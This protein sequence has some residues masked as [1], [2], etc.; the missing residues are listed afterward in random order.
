MSSLS[1][2]LVDAGLSRERLDECRRL[3]N[4]SGD[5]LDRAIL[6]RAYL[7]EA[8]LLEVYASHLGYDFEGQLEGTK[9][10]VSFID[11]VPVHFS[12]N[13][14][15]IA[16]GT[17]EDGAL[18]VATCAPLEP[19]PMDDLAAMLGMDVEPVLSP[20]NEI[21]TLIARAYRHKADGVNQALADVAE[22]GDIAGLAS[23]ISDAEDVLDV[24][25]KAPIIKLV[26]TILFQ[27]LKLR[28]SD[29]HFHPYEDRTQVRFRIDGIL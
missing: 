12:R 19:Q 21:T 17:S 10:P 22:D 13:Y 11:A 9:V 14:N 8:K 25:N 24:S 15:L 3:A 1:E 29:V 4:T 26:N 16:L 28:S 23:E 5:S 27:A 18:R 20:R 6:N 2:L 7:P